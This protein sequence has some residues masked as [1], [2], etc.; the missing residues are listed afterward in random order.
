[1]FYIRIQFFY[2]LDAHHLSEIYDEVACGT[3]DLK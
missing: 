2:L 1:M 3:E